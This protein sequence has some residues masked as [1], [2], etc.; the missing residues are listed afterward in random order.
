M[1]IYLALI[2]LCFSSCTTKKDIKN[3]NSSCN[4]NLKFKVEFFKNIQN[5]ENQLTTEKD[6][7]F[8]ISLKFIAKYAHVSFESMANYAHTYPIGV[9]EKDKKVWLKWYEENKCS[10]IQFK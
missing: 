7:N 10:N 5:I 9:F 2:I 8:N 1:R 6:D 4:E 3:Q